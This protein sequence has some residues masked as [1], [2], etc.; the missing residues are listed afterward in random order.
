VLV[1]FEQQSIPALAGAS[2]VRQYIKRPNMRIATFTLILNL[3]YLVSCSQE[4]KKFENWD[5]RVNKASGELLI[6]TKEF[7]SENGILMN[8]MYNITYGIEKYTIDSI[9]YLFDSSFDTLIY[10][11]P[12]GETPV[13]KEDF[14]SQ[15]F[16]CNKYNQHNYFIE[17]AYENGKL[18][19]R[20]T[21]PIY[22][23]K[24]DS[25]IYLFTPF[26]DSIYYSYHPKIIF[27]L[28]RK[29]G[30]GDTIN[31]DNSRFSAVMDIKKT[32]RSTYYLI[33][34]NYDS[35]ANREEF[36]Y[37]ISDKLEI[38]QLGDYKLLNV[39]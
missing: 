28:K 15:D 11:L 8:K 3:V 5:T 13:S 35:F 26:K 2:A 24:K 18:I 16:H 39:E 25:C 7:L 33:K 36:D 22:F 37:L 38:I 1:D 4:V 10:V 30:I 21:H 23:L 32:N 9:P 14:I 34:T 6:K 12:S 17:G 31:V 29:P 27:N 20:D 19:I